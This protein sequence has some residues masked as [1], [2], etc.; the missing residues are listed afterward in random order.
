LA[1]SLEPTLEQILISVVIRNS[2]SQ[3]LPPNATPRQALALAIAHKWPLEDLLPQLHDFTKSACREGLIIPLRTQPLGEIVFVPT[4]RAIE[5]GRAGKFGKE[6]ATF[7]KHTLNSKVGYDLGKQIAKIP[8]LNGASIDPAYTDDLSPELRLRVN[9]ILQNMEAQELKAKRR[10]ALNKSEQFII[11]PQTPV[12]VLEKTNF[13]LGTKVIG[14]QWAAENSYKLLFE[15][16][17]TGPLE[18]GKT[19]K[20]TFKSVRPEEGAEPV[21]V[22]FWV[23]ANKPAEQ[24]ARKP[25]DFSE[26]GEPLVFTFRYQAPTP[27]A[28]H[29]FQVKGWTH[30]P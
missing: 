14:W 12:E 6:I 20:W 23:K 4:E 26:N 21:E 2:L 9:S 28:L 17:K 16:G 1:K 8:I 3:S 19:Y 27:I 15:D 11:A 13:R 29:G 5:Q 22:A 7:L 18:I 10:A 30:L 24:A 25:L